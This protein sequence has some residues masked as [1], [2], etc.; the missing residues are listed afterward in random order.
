MVYED[1]CCA[2][3]LRQ[4]RNLGMEPVGAF[5]HGNKLVTGAISST[6]VCLYLANFVEIYSTMKFGL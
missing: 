6:E 1:V 3:K 4:A 5:Y 2:T